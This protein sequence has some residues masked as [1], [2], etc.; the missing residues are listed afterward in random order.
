MVWNDEFST[1]GLPDAPNGATMWAAAAG[2]IMNSKYTNARLE[3]AS[4]ADGVLSIT[5]RK[6][7]YE[8]SNYVVRPHDELGQRRLA[9]RKSRR[10]GNPAVWVSG[11]R[12]G[13]CPRTGNTAAGRPAENWT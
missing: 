11:L 1:P 2:A 4:V 5:A 13:F 7:S 6:E 3:N 9:V 10:P 12:Y 8:G